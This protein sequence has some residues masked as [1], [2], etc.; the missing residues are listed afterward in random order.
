MFISDGSKVEIPNLHEVKEEFDVA[1]DTEKYTQHSLTL[2][3]TLIDVK[4]E[5]VLE[6][7]LGKS[8]SSERNL[9]KK[10]LK[11]VKKCVDFEKTIII[12]DKDYYSLE[13]MLSF[14]LLGLKYIFRLKSDTCGE[15]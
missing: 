2:F 14:D 3:S 12:P 10:H 1:S 9:L 5:L 13:L 11:N 4:Y 8:C 15:E 7:I 6:S